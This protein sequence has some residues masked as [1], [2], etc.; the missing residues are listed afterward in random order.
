MMERDDEQPIGGDIELDDAYWGGKKSGT[1]GHGS[2]SKT[3]FVAAVEKQNGKPHRVKLNVVSGFSKAAIEGWAKQ[4]VQ[5]GSNVLSDGLWCFG[6]V[7]QAGCTHQVVV[8]GDSRDPSRTAPFKW[9]NTVLGNLK[10]AMAGTF[11]TLAPQHLKRH[12]ATF[13][14][15]FDRRYNLPEMLPRLAYAALKTLPMP[16]RI[17]KQAE[18]S[19]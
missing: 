5:A 9:V 16:K 19:G 4:H 1:R 6:A 15:R 11:H 2:E 12:L 18:Y 13:A 7:A 8:V 3:P 14:Y 10:T 17:I